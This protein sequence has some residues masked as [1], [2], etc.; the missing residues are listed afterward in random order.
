MSI[1]IVRER[2]SVLMKRDEKGRTGVFIKRVLASDESFEE[3]LRKLEV[4]N[5]AVRKIIKTRGLI[6]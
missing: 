1:D 2:V 3:V 4:R 6:I 5:P